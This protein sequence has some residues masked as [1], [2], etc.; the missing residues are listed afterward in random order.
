[1]SGYPVAGRGKGQVTSMPSPFGVKDPKVGSCIVVGGVPAARIG[2]GTGEVTVLL[3]S[4]KKV[5]AETGTHSIY[6]GR[7]AITAL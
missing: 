6:V 7:C 2:I 3:V 4:R 5:I 1:M